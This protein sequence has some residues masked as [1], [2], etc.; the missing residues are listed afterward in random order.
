[1]VALLTAWSLKSTDIH[2]INLSYVLCSKCTYSALWFIENIDTVHKLPRSG[3]ARQCIKFFVI[4]TVSRD[5]KH[6]FWSKHSTWALCEQANNGFMK[7]VYSCV[8]NYILREN[9]LQNRRDLN[10]FKEQ[11]G[12]INP[13]Q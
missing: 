7:N 13:T 4:E 2:L 10:G 9:I 12:E 8:V 5:L 3:C 11:S 6:F 1:M